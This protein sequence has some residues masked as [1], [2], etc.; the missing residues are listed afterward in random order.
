MSAI[1]GIVFDFD[2]VIV[3]S[4]P[5]HLRSAQDALATRGLTVESGEYY[6]RYVGY[7]DVGMFTEYARE[8]G[9]ALDTC[10]LSE[11]LAAKAMRFA[12]LE[13]SDAA[14]VPG[15]AECVGR[16]AGLAPLAIASGARRDEIERML[17]RAG[18]ARHFPV[19]VAAGD[20]AFG[21]PAP[22]PYARAA[23][24]LG[25]T[26]ARTFA[27]EDTAAGLASAR[28][29]G[30]LCIAVTTTFPASKLQ[31]AHRIVG[32]LDEITVDL[33]RAIMVP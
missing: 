27:I 31:V 17:A 8:H 6:D 16:L 3:N 19:I 10:G 13:T 29:A 1:E 32:S 26:P 23:R 21:K 15:A 4:E 24:L 9:I 7:D 20:T 30:L 11:L 33:L 28:A 12:E 2:G 22:D 14:L 18:L 5:L 25:A